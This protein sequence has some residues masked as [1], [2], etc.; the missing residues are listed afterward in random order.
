LILILN[1]F[2]D[3]IVEVIIESSQTP[4]S[5]YECS[6]EGFQHLE[7]NV[8]T[9]FPFDDLDPSQN[10]FAEEVSPAD[11]DIDLSPLLKEEIKH[12]IKARRI[13]EGKEEI[14]VEFKEPSPERV[15]IDSNR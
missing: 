1:L 14:R 15:S 12:K 2:A 8:P 3:P 4:T 6:S 7:E 5:S 11:V 9:H 10:F 13:A